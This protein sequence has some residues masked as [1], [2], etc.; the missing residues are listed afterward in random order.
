MI[1]NRIKR[2]KNNERHLQSIYNRLVIE[3]AIKMFI[4]N[5]LFNN[6]REKTIVWLKNVLDMFTRFLKEKF[7]NA[8]I[9]VDSITRADILEFLTLMKEKGNKPISINGKI[10]VL[11]LFFSFL[12]REKLIKINPTEDINMLKFT[13]PVI[14][15]F[16]KKQIELLLQQPDIETFVGYRN[17]VIMFTLIESGVRLNELME[18]KV[19]DLLWEDNKNPFGFNIHS[20]KSRRERIGFLSRRAAIVI[21]KWLEERKQ[22]GV[23]SEY[24]FPNINGERLSNRTIQK[25]IADYGKK[26]GIKGVRV[27]PHTF[28]HYFACR[29][30][31]QGGDL[32]TLKEILGHSTLDMTIKYGRMF[33]PDIRKKHEKYSPFSSMHFNDFDF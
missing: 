6:S 31:V 28:R 10:R 17:K 29:F 32:A 11:R 33:S 12:I 15:I 20:P 1:T 2:K 24:L 7:N 13:E 16:T 25:H 14:N 30:L 18:T 5:H 9:F 23:E 8:P 21:K 3:I 27:S 26:A 4:D 22:Y 19:A